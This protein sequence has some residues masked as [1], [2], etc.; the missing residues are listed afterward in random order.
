MDIKFVFSYSTGN[1]GNLFYCLYVDVLIWDV[2]VAEGVCLCECN[3]MCVYEGYDVSWEE[4]ANSV[5]C[6]HTLCH[7]DMVDQVSCCFLNSISLLYC[8][9]RWYDHVLR[10]DD[11]EWVKK[12]TDFVVEGV[13]PRGDQGSNGVGYEEFE[14]KKEDAL[15]CGKWRWLIRGTEEDSDDSGG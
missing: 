8:W 13:R 15:V 6:L 7:S 4:D 14:A 1:Y 2:S 9:L 12:C 3:C 10:K 5:T 11:S